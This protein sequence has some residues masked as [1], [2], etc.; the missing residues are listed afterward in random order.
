MKAWRLLACS[1]LPLL[2]LQNLLLWILTQN[3]GTMPQWVCVRNKPLARGAV[4][5]VVPALDPA[6]LGHAA[7]PG[8]TPTRLVRMPRSSDG[9]STVMHELL[10]LKLPNASF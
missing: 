8:F 10:Q 4:I 5:V 1:L 7:G 3:L 6:E 9:A 2:E